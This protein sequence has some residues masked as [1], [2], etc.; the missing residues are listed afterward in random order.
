[1]EINFPYQ[2]QAVGCIKGYVRKF[3]QGSTDH[4]GVP[5]AVS[6]VPQVVLHSWEIFLISKNELFL[7][8]YIL[9]LNIII[10]KYS[11]A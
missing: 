9:L 8:N 1:M 11:S 10:V 3:W 6:T 2:Q 7:E 4:R 5:G